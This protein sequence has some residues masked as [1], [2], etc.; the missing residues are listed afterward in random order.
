MSN[1][2]GKIE[3]KARGYFP[4]FLAPAAKK[5]IAYPR[6][7]E[8][9]RKSKTQFSIYKNKYRQNIL[10]VAG[11]PKSG[12]TWLEKMLG[13]F[14]GFTDVMIPEA[15]AYEQKNGQSHLFELPGNIFSRF[16]ESLA[17]LKLH[18]HGS[19]R[20]FSILEKH[21]LRYVVLYRDLR[22]VAVSHVF[23]VQSTA[24]H[25]QHALY[26]RLNTKHALIHF[27]NTL[28]PEFIDWVDSWHQH[29]SSPL[30]YVLKY[31]DLLKAPYEKLTE[32]VNHYCINTSDDEI[33]TII[34][35]NSF[36]SMKGGKTSDEGENSFFRKGESGDWKNHFD[37]ELKEIYRIALKDFNDKYGYND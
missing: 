15:V 37:V 19:F 21:N 23:Y 16:N 24:Y 1:I 22:D 32:V 4:S 9:L 25:P 36:E 11:L 28:L 31:E 29:E 10:F 8:Q 27:A 26:K 5:F 12:T 17:V 7:Y 6:Y 33:K 13:S 3:K 30:S 2:F 34:Q 35:K 20:N 14:P 18:A